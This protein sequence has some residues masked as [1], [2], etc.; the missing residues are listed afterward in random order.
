MDVSIII[1][2]YNTWELTLSCIDSVF[3][4]TRNLNFEVIVV[5]N[6]STDGSKN[7]FEK[8]PRIIYI[9][10]EENLG[11]GKA[12]NVGLD[13]ARGKYLFL[14][15]S[16]TLLQENSILV[17]YQFME[18]HAS[19]YS[20]GACGCQLINQEKKVIHSY[21]FFPSIKDILFDTMNIL[22]SIFR[23]SK[24]TREKYQFN[25]DGFQLVD[26][27]TGA[28]LF[29][30]KDVID[31]ELEY[32]FDPKFFMYYE[33]TDLQLRMSELGFRR[34]IIDNTQI[35][36]MEGSSVVMSGRSQPKNCFM[37]Y[38]FILLSLHYYCRKNFAS[39]Y[40]CLYL[41]LF[42]L[43][44]LP[45]ILY[46]NMSNTQRLKTIFTSVTGKNLNSSSL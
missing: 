38:Q 26:Y 16:D 45:R 14:L 7:Y 31:N 12:N 42:N 37:Q 5:D 11:F 8:D 3:W 15:N 43:L 34:G 24:Q 9:Y 13:K 1:V 22:K 19:R 29:I 32:L 30:R 2:N 6:A 17:L 21:G 18:K 35:I 10:N 27:I 25:S 39:W 46:K 40:R 44:I 36:H 41:L 33:E 20:I 28:D 4:H 23:L